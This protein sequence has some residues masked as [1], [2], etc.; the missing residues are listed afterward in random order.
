LKLYVSPL[1]KALR[2]PSDEADQGWPS[3]QL[4]TTFRSKFDEARVQSLCAPSIH[5]Q[6]NTYTVQ[7]TPA[8]VS[9]CKGCF[10]LFYIVS[11]WSSSIYACHRFIPLNFFVTML[12]CRHPAALALDPQA[13]DTRS[14]AGTFP[15]LSLPA[16][17]R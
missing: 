4:C 3:A 5:E 12:N 17:S 14:V 15:L 13:I 10:L 16:N 1:V 7:V 8:S 11:L 6:L 9:W 2:E